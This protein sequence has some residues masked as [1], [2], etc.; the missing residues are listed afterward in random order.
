V[1]KGPVP[2]KRK[3]VKV[4]QENGSMKVV[5]EQK[6]DPA[7]KRLDPLNLFPDG[8]CGENIHNGSHIWER[9]YLTEK[10]LRD[11]KGLP[12]YLDSEIDACIEEGPQSAT[13]ISDA[14]LPQGQDQEDIKGRYE[15]WY[16]TGTIDRKDMEAL[17][18]KCPEGDS[19]YAQVTMIN[20]HV[21]KGVLNPLDTGDFP[22]DVMVWQRQAGKWTGTGVSRQIR[23]PQR[24]VNSATR[25][26][27]D[28]AGISSGPQI[29]FKLGVV[30]PADGNDAN[31][32]AKGLVHR[33]ER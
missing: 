13:E 29:V 28:N 32:A 5:I 6:I 18:C 11:L 24:M 19:V 21:I 17:G 23:T 10:T 27:M 1:L 25:A 7:S 26:M 22:Y 8:A 9:D 33:S 31:D 2:V 14:L 16:Y 20:K 15:V 4:L 3:S 30:R 12:G